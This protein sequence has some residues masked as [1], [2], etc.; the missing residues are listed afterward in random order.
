MRRSGEGGEADPPAPLLETLHRDV[1]DVYKR[2]APLL[3][4]ELSLVL[5]RLKGPSPRGIANILDCTWEDLTAGA[6][7]RRG[8]QTLK[9]AERRGLLGAVAS[10]PARKAPLNAHGLKTH[11]PSQ[12]NATTGQFSSTHT[13][14]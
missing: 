11:T 10:T 5:S 7:V 14:I 9:P 3:L 8:A 1:L 4:S 12:G 13:N 2:D 6:L